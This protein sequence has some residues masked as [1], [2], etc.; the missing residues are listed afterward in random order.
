MKIRNGFVSNSSSSSFT[1]EVCGFSEETYDGSGEYEW[2]T[3]ENGHTFCE[4][5]KR[6]PD[7]ISSEIMREALIKDAEE[8]MTVRQLSEEVL[9]IE[10]LN[11]KQ[12]TEEYEE[13]LE[14]C[15]TDDVPEKD[16]PLCSFREFHND[17][18]LAFMLAD[19]KTTRKDVIAAIKGTFAGREQFMECIKNTK[20]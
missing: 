13:R 11:E 8:R 3:C 19:Q 15:E 17:E 2:F 5:H 6:K 12:L 10:G 7:A 9:R 1:C 20:V 4:K 16:C 18:I 14:D